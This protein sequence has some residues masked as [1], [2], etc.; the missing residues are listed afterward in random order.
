[1]DKIVEG[2]Q[3]VKGRRNPEKSRKKAKVQ[4]LKNT[5]AILKNLED[6]K[7]VEPLIKNESLCPQVKMGRILG[8]GS[9]GKVYIA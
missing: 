3:N 1:M 6:G 4:G 9:F 5:K 2:L 7:N 8:E